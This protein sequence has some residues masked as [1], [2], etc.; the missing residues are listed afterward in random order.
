MGTT[1]IPPIIHETQACSA[2]AR[3]NRIREAR[4]LLL[5]RMF[6]MDMGESFLFAA[7]LIEDLPDVLESLE[8]RKF[9]KRVRRCGETEKA[10]LL[11][12]LAVDE[13]R[14]LGE[15]TPRQRSVFSA[16]LRMRGM[17]LGGS[18]DREAA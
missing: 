1:L 14:R 10:Q 17:Q 2:L 4:A 3:A 12:V 13:V 16:A 11:A 9:L 5:Q 8:L 6:A 18:I 7:D 15:L